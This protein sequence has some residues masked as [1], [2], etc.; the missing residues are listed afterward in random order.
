M[1]DSDL[2]KFFHDRLAKLIEDL[3]P[4]GGHA[5]GP[6]KPTLHELDTDPQ[7]FKPKKGK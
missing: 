7:T 4:K 6:K 3:K 2:E 1:L 5:T